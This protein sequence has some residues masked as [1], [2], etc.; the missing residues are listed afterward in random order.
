M[1]ED[2]V[3]VSVLSF[4]D[5]GELEA[6]LLHRGSRESCEEAGSLFPA[7]AYSGPRPVIDARI[8]IMESR[9]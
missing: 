6:M 8:M 2:F 4:D 7:I 5:D 9:V 3:C 1:G